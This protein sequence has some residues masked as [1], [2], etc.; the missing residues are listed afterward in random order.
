MSYILFLLKEWVVLV[1]TLKSMLIKIN[2]LF[3]RS[4]L[5]L[6]VLTNKV[7]FPFS[8][9]HSLSPSSLG[10]ELSFYCIYI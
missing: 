1:L 4:L 10:N 2:Q 7:V 9:T 8:D 5:S 6:R 3:T